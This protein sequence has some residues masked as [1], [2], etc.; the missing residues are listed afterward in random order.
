MA[1]V[2][3]GLVLVL[4]RML[5]GKSAS[6]LI[7][8]NLAAAG[9][10]L[11]GVA[12]VDLGAVSARWNVAHA[13]EIDGD[14]AGLDLCYLNDLRGSALPALIALDQRH[15]PGATGGHVAQLRNLAAVRL[16]TWRKQGGWSLLTGRRLAQS[17]A[18]P[19]TTN[20]P[21]PGQEC[22]NYALRD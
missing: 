13:K 2:A 17:R 1:L 18:N 21:A 7:N 10:L 11:T 8:A 19:S 3:V 5:Q 4:W 9:L 16:E 14:G 12:F 22:D 20:Q 6:W 15:L